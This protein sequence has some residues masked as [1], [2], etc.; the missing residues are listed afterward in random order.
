MDNGPVKYR[1][2]KAAPKTVYPMSADA[3]HFVMTPDILV[4]FYVWEKTCRVLFQPEKYARA[5]HD[6]K[7][8]SL[9]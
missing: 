7:W 2:P 1:L 9:S 8:Y 4:D 5:E 6:K 3:L